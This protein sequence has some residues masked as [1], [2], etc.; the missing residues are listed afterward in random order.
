MSDVIAIEVQRS[1]GEKEKL[2]VHHFPAVPRKGDHICLDGK[3]VL[4]VGWIIWVP[5]K[6]EYDGSNYHV[7]QYTT[8]LMLVS[9]PE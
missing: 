6:V 5:M 9:K 8:P 3:D 7:R 1:D 2:G 4:I